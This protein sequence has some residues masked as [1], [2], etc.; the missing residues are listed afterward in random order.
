MNGLV[1]KGGGGMEEEAE[2]VDC[3]DL[4]VEDLLFRLLNAR[5]RLLPVTAVGLD[6]GNEC[7]GGDDRNLDND[8]GRCAWASLAWIGR[9]GSTTSRIKVN[10]RTVYRY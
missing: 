5:K 3:A 10:Q 7:L 9:T 4:R 6:D 2:Y 8:S 1:G